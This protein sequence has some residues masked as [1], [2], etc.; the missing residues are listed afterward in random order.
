MQVWRPALPALDFPTPIGLAAGFD[1]NG[2]AIRALAGLGFGS[3]EIGSVSVDPSQGNPKPRLWRM[4]EDEAIVVHYGLPNDGASA[5]AER[6]KH[7]HLPVPLRHQPRRHQ[8]GPGAAPLKA[9]QIIG[10][11]RRRREIDGAIRSTT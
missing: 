6:L 9:Y 10:E 5:I 8:S 1:K 2:T 4:A 3:V 7:I 11:I